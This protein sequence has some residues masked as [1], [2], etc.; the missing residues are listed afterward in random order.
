MA[1]VDTVHNRSETRGFIVTHSLHYRVLYGLQ[2]VGVYPS[3]SIS[4]IRAEVM[5]P[6]G[7]A[8]RPVGGAVKAALLLGLP[9]INAFSTITMRS[10]ASRGGHDTTVR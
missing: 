4:S 8:S 1:A 5:P 9:V 7:D 10:T 2:V 6:R 3:Q